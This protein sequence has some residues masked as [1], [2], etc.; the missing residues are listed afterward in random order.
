MTDP[1][2]T[3]AIEKMG[4]AA[5]LAAALGITRSAVSQWQTIPSWHIADVSRIT[6]IPVE[7]LVSSNRKRASAA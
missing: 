3:R 6:G 4:S 7:D 2:V 1:T 5:K